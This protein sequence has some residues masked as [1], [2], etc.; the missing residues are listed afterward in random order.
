MALFME[1]ECYQRLSDDFSTLIE[2]LP[3]KLSA[4]QGSMPC[5]IHTG[6]VL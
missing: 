2:W 3:M 5:L 6:A 1:E 4:L